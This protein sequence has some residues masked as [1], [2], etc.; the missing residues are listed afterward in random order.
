M[1]KFEVLQGVVVEDCGRDAA[2]GMATYWAAARVRQWAVMLYEPLQGFE[3]QVETVEAHVAALQPGDDRKGLG[4]MIESTVECEALIES[5][6]P[7]MAKRRMAEI[8]GESAGLR[9]ILLEAE[10]AREGPRNLGDLKGMG[11]AGAIVVAFVIDKD[12]GLVGEPPK[13]R[14]MDNAVAIAAEIVARRARWLIME[15]TATCS[16]MRRER[17]PCRA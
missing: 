1:I 13:C 14:G 16:R 2:G 15:T 4:V 9:E 10:R 17:R 8:V 5:A 12:L 3:R 7:R 6:L 11:E